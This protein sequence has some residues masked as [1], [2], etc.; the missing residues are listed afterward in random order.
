[1]YENPIKTKMDCRQRPGGK[2][3]IVPANAKDQ[4]YK[5]DFICASVIRSSFGILYFRAGST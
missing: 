1:M 3:V 2:L 4:E 5:F